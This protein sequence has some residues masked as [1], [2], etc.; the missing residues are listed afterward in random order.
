MRRWMRRAAIIRSRRLRWLIA[1][2]AFLLLLA[3]ADD[4]ATTIPTTALFFGDSISDNSMMLYQG[5]YADTVVAAMGWTRLNQDGVNPDR[6]AIQG[7]PLQHI[8]GVADCGVDTFD[9]RVAPYA[10]DILVIYYGTNDYAYSSA[11][12][13]PASY[14]AAWETTF[15][16]IAMLPKQPRV[17]LIGLR[18][19]IPPYH[20]DR[21][22]PWATSSEDTQGQLN[23]VIA[24]VAEEHGAHYVPIDDLTE[25]D[26]LPDQ[27]HPNAS[28]QAKIAAHLLAAV[29]SPLPSP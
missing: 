21:L 2:P 19:L 3:A 23:A 27:L 20:V 16:Q 17:Y 13:T 5:M 8:D 11:T 12:V 6:A 4:G 22:P 25:N 1:C 29:R 10:P 14:R 28:G 26:Y 7:T 18:V 24:T 15:A 9:R